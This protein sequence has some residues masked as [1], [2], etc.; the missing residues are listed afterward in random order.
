MNTANQWAHVLSATEMDGAY[1]LTRRLDPGFADGQ[2]E[3]YEQRT[4]AQLDSLAHQA[5]QCN[6]ADG[7]QLARSYAAQKVIA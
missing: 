2:R 6:D 7:Y 4:P 5:W 1:A 3:F